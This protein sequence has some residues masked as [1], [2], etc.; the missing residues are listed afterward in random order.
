MMLQQYDFVHPGA[1]ARI[2]QLAEDQ[3]RH[4]MSLERAVITS[5]VRR[6][7]AGLV[8]GFILGGSVLAAGTS[9]VAYSHDTAG[10]AI[11]TSSMAT[12]AGVF[13]YGRKSQATER[14]E[15]A[16]IMSGKKK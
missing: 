15:K 14:V 7:W 10:A 12:I 6:S 1:A 16:K 13:V 8:A 2:L 9:L 4:R 3:S 5:D 11:I